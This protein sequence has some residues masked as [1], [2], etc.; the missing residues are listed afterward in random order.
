MAA[1]E[2]CNVRKS[3]PGSNHDTLK[4]IDLKIDDGEFLILVGPSGCGKSTLMNCIYWRTS[5]GVNKPPLP[6]K[7]SAPDIT[8]PFRN[9]TFDRP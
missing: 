3:Y 6:S 4:D 5:R 8:K 7:R 2:L 9:A 1:L